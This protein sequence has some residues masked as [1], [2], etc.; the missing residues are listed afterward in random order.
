PLL[1]R[2]VAGEAPASA[3]FDLAM[4]RQDLN[5]MAGAAAAYRKVLSLQPDHSEAAVNLGV[6]HQDSGDMEAALEAFRTAYRLR[7]STFGVIANA[8]TSAPHGRMWID[9]DD[10]RRLLGA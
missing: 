10:L 9:L 1:E 6:V 5:D 8:L 2:A 4:A 3:W 7:P